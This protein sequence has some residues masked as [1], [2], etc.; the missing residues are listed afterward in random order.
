MR[1]A[2]VIGFASLFTLWLLLFACAPLLAPYDARRVAQHQEPLFCWSRW[3]GQRWEMLDGGTEIYRGFGYEVLAK[4][5]AMGVV[6]I[7]Y[8]T[9]VEVVFTLPCYRRCDFATTV[10][11][12][13]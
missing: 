2:L 13:Q 7:R 5:R 8:D 6:P 4:H 11:S 9:G 12:A 10:E 3:F 1:R